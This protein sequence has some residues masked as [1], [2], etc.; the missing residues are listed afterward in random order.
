[1]RATEEKPLTEK[2]GSTVQVLY[3]FFDRRLSE[4]AWESHLRKLPEE[5]QIRILRYRRWEDRQAGVFG[6]LLLMEGLKGFGYTVNAISRTRPDA[7]GRPALECRVDF[8][9]SHSGEYV[10]CAVSNDTRV[11]IDIEKRKAFRFRDLADCFSAEEWEEMAKSGD[12]EAAFYNFWTM[13]ESVL[14]ADGKGLSMPMNRVRI[15]DGRANLEGA[16]WFLRELDFGPDYSCHLATDHEVSTIKMKKVGFDQGSD[17][18]RAG[19]L[20][21]YLDCPSAI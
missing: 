14:K 11:G 1:V 19:H 18:C 12:G 20:G 16:M 5:T 13:K 6:K 7:H 3:T 8:N 2:K 10:V 21:H 9:I 17:A 15:K 4:Q